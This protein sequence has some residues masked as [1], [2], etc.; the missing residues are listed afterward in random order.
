MNCYEAEP[1]L[2]PYLDG[3]LDVVTAMRM[4]EHIAGCGVCGR[5]Y[6]DL[7]NLR[8]EIAEAE[9]GYVPKPRL[10]RRVRGIGPRPWRR[11]STTWMVAAAALLTMTFSLRVMH[12][13]GAG[14]REVVEDHL[15][16]LMASH[17]VDVPSSD[18]HTVKPWFQGKL[19]F[20]PDV[21]ELGSQGFELVGG[22]M[23]RIEGAPAA[24]I[25]YRRRQHVINLF[26]APTDHGDSGPHG[27]SFDGYSVVEWAKGG[28]RYW[29]VSD[30]NRQELSRFGELASGR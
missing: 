14:D 3:E 13:G 25:V 9:L 2:H 17:L 19:S 6:T 20:S 8:R 29:A 22:R 4:E 16:S 30:L 11:H 7:Q 18:H 23:E 26:V 5:E 10:E 12:T 15:R 24:A 21:P 1:L 27:S 28:L